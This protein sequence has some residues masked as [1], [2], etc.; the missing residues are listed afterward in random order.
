MRSDNVCAGQD[1]GSGESYQRYLDG[2]DASM[3]RSAAT[4]RSVIV[5]SLVWGLTA[6]CDSD[7]STDTG[8][9]QHVA[10][11]E[12]DDAN[13]ALPP[14]PAARRARTPRGKPA[15][16]E[17]PIVRVTEL[18]AAGMGAHPIRPVVEKVHEVEFSTK[19]CA[20]HRGRLRCHRELGAGVR[21]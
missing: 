9:R 10:T 16:G 1:R 5:F 14:A 12:G 13:R 21:Q 15:A 6:S 11:D 3:R 20:A 17:W 7:D 19:G 2:M 4:V 18:V 8:V